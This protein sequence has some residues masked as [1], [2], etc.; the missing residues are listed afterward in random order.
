MTQLWRRLWEGIL[1]ILHQTS[2]LGFSHSQSFTLSSKIWASTDLLLHIWS[3]L[4]LAVTCQKAWIG[5]TCGA[6]HGLGHIGEEGEWQRK[7]LI[8]HS[9]ILTMTEWCQTVLKIH[10]N[11]FRE[12]IFNEIYICVY[13]YMYVIRN[14]WIRHW[15]N[16][17]VYSSVCMWSSAAAHLLS[18][19]HCKG[20]EVSVLACMFYKMWSERNTGCARSPKS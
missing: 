8:Q 13:I 19:S 11:C 20:G 15:L 6:W 18:C 10:W 16:D 4:S 14:A 9:L 5:F 1:V 3:T 7:T 12:Q 2:C 17:F